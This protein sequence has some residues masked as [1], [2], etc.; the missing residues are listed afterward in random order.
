LKAETRIVSLEEELRAVKRGLR[1]QNM[2]QQAFE[3][4]KCEYELAHPVS[5][6]YL[7]LPD[8]S[9]DYDELD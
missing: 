1:D 5:D 8:D 2:R 7:E 4:Y 3:N 9:G 6:F